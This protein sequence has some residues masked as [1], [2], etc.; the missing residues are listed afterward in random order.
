[1]RWGLTGLMFTALCGC[2][3]PSP[4]PGPAVDLRIP[5]GV[6]VFEEGEVTFT[7]GL[8]W[9]GA[10][11]D[12]AF[13]ARDDS[14]GLSIGSTPVAA[15]TSEV[16]LTLGAATGAQGGELSLV[17]RG[18]GV[19]RVVPVAITVATASVVAP[20]SA[21][22]LRGA[23]AA[24]EVLVVGGE[25]LF[26]DVV[27]AE[28][29]GQGRWRVKVAVAPTSP[30]GTQ[31]LSFS[32]GVNGAHRA[33]TVP[34]TVTDTVTVNVVDYY[35]EGLEGHETFV[36]ASAPKLTDTQ[37]R[38]TFSGVTAPYRLTVRRR[39]D[40][41]DAYSYEGVT[42]TEPIV[43]GF[44]S[45]NP[46]RSM[47]LEVRLE[48]GSSGALLSGHSS[49]SVMAFMEGQPPGWAVSFVAG[50]A[51]SAGP[52]PWR[53]TS[54]TQPARLRA[55]ASVAGAM[56]WYAETM[57]TLREGDT[58]SL[59]FQMEPPVFGEIHASLQ[60]P[61]GFSVD[62]KQLHAIFAKNH[63]DR[64]EV[65]ADRSAALQSTLVRALDRDDV[66]HNLLA[67][68]VD[69]AGRRTTRTWTQLALG[70]TATGALPD[71]PRMQGVS[72][73]EINDA[74]LYQWTPGEWPLF[75]LLIRVG[76]G[77]AMRFEV[78]HTS[79]SSLTRPGMVAFPPDTGGTYK[80][81][82]TTHYRTVDDLLR[83]RNTGFERDPLREGASGCDAEQSVT[84]RGAP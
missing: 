82:G 31:D 40:G 62:L 77:D 13:E 30:L 27:E 14:R 37:G 41:A 43:T 5:A 45:K 24:L 11:V 19:E 53:S 79:A 71:P 64:F 20:P 51:E 47:T 8:E 12:L 81:C 1:M 69:L 63:F 68:A 3:G 26:A 67:T 44:E 23:A 7:V 52:I 80:I 32:V 6:T 74:T 22:V 83:E 17:A 73:T 33:L 28:A 21:P 29:A 34:V 78:I 55:I 18:D 59:V 58:R 66:E 9:D 39:V 48:Q 65:D 50:G 2:G 70:D 25:P 56:A 49:A 16:H 35:G 46:Q 72:T 60:V 75:Q 76:T 4:S 84:Y 54:P 15:G 61:A 42:L 10:P 36:N 38:A 57:L